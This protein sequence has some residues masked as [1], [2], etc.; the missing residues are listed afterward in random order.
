VSN[1]YVN[2]SRNVTIINNTTII[3]SRV[4]NVNNNNNRTVYVNG[5]DR[6]EVER[7]TGSPIRPAVIRENNRPGEQVNNDQYTIYRP[8]VNSNT[9]RTTGNQTVRVAPSRV[10]SLRDI[11]PTS[12]TGNLNSQRISL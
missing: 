4:V 2:E 5:P 9:Q 3:N 6:Q 7:V 10:E 8:R 12:S 1:Y 11:R